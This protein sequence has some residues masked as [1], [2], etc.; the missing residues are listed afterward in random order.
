[1]KKTFKFNDTVKTTKGQPLIGAI[2]QTHP[3]D[4]SADVTSFKTG[5]IWNV[6]YEILQKISNRKADSEF[7]RLR[8]KLG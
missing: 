7:S 1:M 4:K 3:A 8:H 2:L 5:V 6:P